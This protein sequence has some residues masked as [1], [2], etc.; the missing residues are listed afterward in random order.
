MPDRAALQDA[1]DDAVRAQ[2]KGHGDAGTIARHTLFYLYGGDVDGLSAA[3]RAAGYQVRPTARNDGVVLETTTAV[4]RSSFAPHQRRM[5][6]WA[7][8]FRSDYDG[9]ECAVVTN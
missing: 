9:W 3:A 1:K 5:L 4:D 7:S 8:Q 2:L 6:D